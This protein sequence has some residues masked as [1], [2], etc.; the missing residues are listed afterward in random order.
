M[1]HLYNKGDHVVI[2]DDLK[3]GTY[4]AMFK[5]DN[6]DIVTE[7][8]TPEM[9]RMA[10]RLVTIQSVNHRGKY[11]IVEDGGNYWWI[12]TFF[13]GREEDAE[14]IAASVLPLESLFS[15]A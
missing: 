2:R 9:E 7:L 3:R 14:P 6:G 13:G 5:E 8:C 1:K 12:D 10:G 4:T 15:R 11:K